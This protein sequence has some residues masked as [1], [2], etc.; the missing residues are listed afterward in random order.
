MVLQFEQKDEQICSSAHHASSLGR[1][2]IFWDHNMTAILRR[3]THHRE[4]PKLP[5]NTQYNTKHRVSPNFPRA[6]VSCQVR[7]SRRTCRTNHPGR[8][9]HD[10][11]VRMGNHPPLSHRKFRSNTA[12]GYTWRRHYEQMVIVPSKNNPLNSKIFEFFE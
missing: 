2:S 1:Y 8:Q 10:H 12:C 3:S 9:A 7:Q 5:N 4:F 11:Q 6:S